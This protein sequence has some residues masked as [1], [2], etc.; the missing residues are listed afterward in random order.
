MAT[1]YGYAGNG[2]VYNRSTGQQMP[3]AQAAAENGGVP[4]DF[5]QDPAATALMASEGGHSTGASPT[6][7]AGAYGGGAGLA[8]LFKQPDVTLP[9]SAAAET[10]LR[11]SQMQGVNGLSGLINGNYDAQT[12]ATRKA[13]YDNASSDINYSGDRLHQDALEQQNGKNFLNSS[14]TGDYFL[15]PIERNRAVALEK[16]SNDATTQAQAMTNANLTTQAGLLGQAFAQGNTGLQSEANVQASNRTANQAATQAGYQTGLQADQNAAALAQQNTQFGQ[17]LSQTK[18]LQEQAFQNAKDIN[19]SNA[20]GSG[21]GGLANL[22]A[23]QL[24]AG[25]TALAKSAFGS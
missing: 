18:D 15:D 13:L 23:P 10:A 20:I 11:A 4:P 17:S 25:A 2:I 9:D 21:I 22:F 19:S 5:S 8:A 24:Q 16:A 14:V 1:S 3:M 7:G 6:T 12:A